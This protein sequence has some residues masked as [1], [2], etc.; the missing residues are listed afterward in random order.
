MVV[1][2]AGEKDCKDPSTG[3]T[4]ECV[5]CFEDFEVV[6]EIARLECLCRYHK[7]CIKSWF[8]RKGNGECPVH[9][10]HE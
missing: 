3:E 4:V 8:E 10:I 2:R 9:A 6:Q 5:I 7:T 1:W